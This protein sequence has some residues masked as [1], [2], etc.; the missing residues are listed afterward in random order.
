M[1]TKDYIPQKAE[2]SGVYKKIYYLFL[3]IC[4]YQLPFRKTFLAEDLLP[5]PLCI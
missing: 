3:S 5:L 4:I 1:I 2:P